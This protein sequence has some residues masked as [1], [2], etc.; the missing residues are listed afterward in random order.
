MPFFTYKAIDNSGQVVTGSI[1]DIHIEQA[2][3]NVSAFGFHVLKI[4]KC[5][6]LS[7]IYLKKTRLWGIKTS[8]IIEFASNLSVMVKAGLPLVTSI[9][10]IAESL[11]NKRFKERLLEI[12]RYIDLGSGFSAALSN[13]RDIFPEIFINLVAIGEE[14]GRLDASLSD[15]AVHLQR[16][17]DLRN[18]IIRALIYPVFALVGT[19][20]ALLFWLMYVLPKMT[21]LFSAMDM[22]LPAITR[23][24]IIASDFS[25]ANWYI[26]IVIP[27]I[28]YAF[29]ILL[30]RYE[31]T[32][33]YIDMAKLRLPILKLILYNK[34]L[35][36]FVEQMRILLSAGIAIDKSFDIMIKVVSNVVFKR[37]LIQT[38]EDILLGSQMS[39]SLK[40]HKGLFPNL[41]VRMI[42][43]GESTGRIEEQLNYLSEYFLNKLDDISEK[44]GKLIEPIVIVVI[45]LLFMVII[46]GLMSPIYDLVAGAGN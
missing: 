21:G 16:M 36:L 7:D 28:V 4:Q 15:I 25:R 44:I 31:R 6:S 45:G 20:G 30:S 10:D 24:L 38:K 29:F 13:H 3:D 27:V 11:E 40:K 41:V 1:E 33:Y 17:E 46:M 19:T 18:A 9:S 35:A 22:E 2:Y 5:S 12:N 32:K 26:Y 14:T 37:A 43:I 42:S 8:D 23:A 39:E 34:L